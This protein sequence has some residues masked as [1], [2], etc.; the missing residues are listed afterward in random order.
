MQVNNKQSFYLYSFIVFAIILVIN[1]IAFNRPMRIDLTDNQIFTLS[2]STKSV[3]SK[4]DDNL[5]VSIYFSNDLPSV[6]SNNS[7]FIQDIL[8]EYQA[9][10]NG[11]IRFEFKDPDNDE[12][13]KKDA[14]ALG[15]Q[16]VQVNV[17]ENDRRELNF[18]E[19]LSVFRKCSSR[20]SKFF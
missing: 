11:K 15:I 5:V 4:I 16:P 18:R 3:I 20:I 12:V 6:L 1:L 9:R 10:S 8:E 14:Q 17:W 13:A 7:R 2:E 19:R